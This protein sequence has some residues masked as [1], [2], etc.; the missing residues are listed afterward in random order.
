MRAAYSASQD[1]WA[2]AIGSVQVAGGSAGDAARTVA[3]GLDAT[4]AIARAMSKVRA[5][6]GYE[7]GQRAWGSAWAECGAARAVLDLPGLRRADLLAMMM[8]ID[9]TN[10]ALEQVERGLWGE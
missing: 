8:K 2:D 9:G 3:G 4:C 1:A 6:A 7:A 5:P 10:A